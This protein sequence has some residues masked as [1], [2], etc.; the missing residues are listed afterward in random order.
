M[1]FS[2]LEFIMNKRR[3][4][5]VRFLL[6]GAAVT[7]LSF[8]TGCEHAALEPAF[9]DNNAPEIL[10]IEATPTNVP[11]GSKSIIFVEA[12]DV[13]GDTLNYRWNANKGTILGGGALVEW[14]APATEGTATIAVQVDDGNE[15]RDE[16]EIKI[17]IITADPANKPPVIQNLRAD[18]TVIKGGNRTTLRVDAED[19][20]GD[21]L[22]YTWT[23]TAGKISGSGAEVIWEAPLDNS[24]F[25]QQQITVMVT[26]D[27]GG[28]AFR[29]LQI[30]VR[31][32]YPLPVVD[33]LSAQPLQ[34]FLG[35]SSTISVSASSPTGSPLSY[36]WR[37]S[38]GEFSGE[39]SPSDSVVTWLAPSGPVCCAPGPYEII[40]TVRNEEGGET[41]ASIIVTVKL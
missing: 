7:L 1:L 34:V 39:P 19:A 37:A 4:V 12:T 30:Q 10:K 32:P 33:S 24:Q 36:E 28:A 18:S 40:V 22:K 14:F 27:R 21:A 31:S 29:T 38:G 41:E 11:L 17:R 23:K 5:F 13:D 35:G 9:L 8:Q 6:I 15:G 16:A 25:R 26:D 3:L 2:F 20:D